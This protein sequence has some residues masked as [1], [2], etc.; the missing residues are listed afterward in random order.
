M[1]NKNKAGKNWKSNFRNDIIDILQFLGG[2]PFSGRVLLRTFLGFG[3]F[4][5]DIQLKYDIDVLH[6]LIGE[7][8][9]NG[10]ILTSLLIYTS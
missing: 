3:L 6:M 8:E 5:N 4:W 9:M 7:P 2:N 1:G 10:E